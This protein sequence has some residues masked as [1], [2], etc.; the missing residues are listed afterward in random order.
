VFEGGKRVPVGRDARPG[1][2]PL[3]T[4][5][6]EGPLTLAV[7]CRTDP[8][9]RGAAHQITIQPDWQVR[10][11]H[12]LEAERVALAFGGYLSCIS[13]VDRVVPA[14]A[15]LAQL[16]GRRRLPAVRRHGNQDW[17]MAEPVERCRCAGKSFRM[18]ELAAFHA[19]GVEHWAARWGVTPRRLTYLVEAVA[20]SHRIG[21]RVGRHSRRCVVR[22]PSG[23]DDLWQ[24]G[25]HPEYVA[26]VHERV[27]PD[28][29]PLQAR[30]YLGA[31]YLGAPLDWLASVAEATSDADVL[32]WAAWT[33]CD[34]DRADPQARLQWLGL[35]LPLRDIERLMSG[36]YTRSTAEELAAMC[37][38][39]ATRV[40]GQLAA[41]Q[42]AGCTPG[43]GDLAALTRVGVDASYRPSPA[44]VDRLMD[45]VAGLRPTPTRTQ[46]ALVLAVAQTVRSA[47]ALLRLGV[48]EP[49][50]AILTLE[51]TT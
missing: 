12:D 31:A 39:D 30:F 11:P 7:E 14:L 22:E 34:L 24:A 46:A 6:P 3:L 49:V 16:I 10:T 1:P 32:T 42:A 28:G 47:A 26:E 40:A 18:P 50:S 33:N 43:P 27:W 2:L 37:G 5:S 35:R 41:W 44:A 13:L 48:R 19:R 38:S 4:P 8:K 45:D 21:E 25:L 29:P 23:L 51:G 17:R 36:G 15:E 9:K 20:R